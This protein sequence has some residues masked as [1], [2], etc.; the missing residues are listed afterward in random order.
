MKRT[1]LVAAADKII[2]R[3][4]GVEDKTPGGIV[5]PDNAK[6][7]PTRGT[8]V[9]VGLGRMLESGSRA[10]MDYDEGDIVIFGRYDGTEVKINGETLFIL[11][12]G[13]ILAS[14]KPEGD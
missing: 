1:N 9:S 2:V 8:V 5:L 14:V 6:E 3:L 13:S 7:K 4:D 10:D 12:A 11:A